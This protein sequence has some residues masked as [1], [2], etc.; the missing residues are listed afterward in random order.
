[1]GLDKINNSRESISFSKLKDQERRRKIQTIE[2]RI[3]KL[4]EERIA[5]SPTQQNLANL[6]SEYENEYD[7]ILKEAQS[8]DPV[9]HGTN[10][11]NGTASIS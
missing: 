7:Y 11:G 10:K 3:K 1:M 8:S 5:Q 6:E 9:L 2:N 4:C